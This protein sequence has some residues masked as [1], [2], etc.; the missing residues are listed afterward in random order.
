MSSSC[1]ILFLFVYILQ[2]IECLILIHQEKDLES[3]AHLPKRCPRSWDSLLCWPPTQPGI[4]A[5]LPCFEELNGIKY[6]TTRKF[7]IILIY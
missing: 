7:V 6:D 5:S 3:V 4:R 1:L 2:E